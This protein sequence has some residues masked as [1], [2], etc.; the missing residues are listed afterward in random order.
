MNSQSLTGNIDTY[1][2]ILIGVAIVLPIQPSRFLP[3]VVCNH[4][5]F[6][7][8]LTMVSPD[9]YSLVSK[10]INT[11]ATAFIAFFIAFF[12]YRFSKKDFISN[13]KLQASEEH[14]RKLFA[15]NPFPLVL[16]R[17]KDDRILQINDKAYDFYELGKGSPVIRSEAVSYC[18]ENKEQ[19]IAEL[20]TNGSIHNR[21]IELRLSAVKAKWA[22]VNFELL[23]YDNDLLL[24]TAVTD[25]TELKKLESKLQVHASVDPLTG[26]INRRRGMELL[27]S[28]LVKARDKYIRFTL[29]F[30]DINNLKKV[31]DQFGHAEGDDMIKRTCHVISSRLN[32]GDYIFRYGGDEFI[33]IL[34]QTETD[35]HIFM[36]HVRQELG[37]I[38]NTRIKPYKL[39]VSYGLYSFHSGINIT[40]EELI[41]LADKEMYKDKQRHR[42]LSR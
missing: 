11:T 8:L 35:S 12:F 42:I 16:T 19:I 27:Q 5:I 28:Q 36:D 41:E 32:G 29:C 31:N 26:V 38:N 34:H 30:I 14:F 21:N 25:I 4:V 23:E 39:A 37:R 2:I 13:R 17:L 24:L 18:H 9:R 40:S 20:Q 1:V 10:Q 7:I 6:L 15:V 33:V 3:I 22:M